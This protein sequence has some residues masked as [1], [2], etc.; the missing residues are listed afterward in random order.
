[1]RFIYTKNFRILFA[2][3][4]IFAMLVIADA[5]GISSGVKGLA[6]KSFGGV[7]RFVATASDQIKNFFSV[8]VTIKSLARENAL[9]N[10][11]INELSFQ[12]ARLNLAKQENT[13]LR[14]ALGLKENFS[15]TLI[16]SEVIQADP[17]GFSQTLVIDKGENQGVTAGAAVVVS[18]GLLVG[19]VTRLLGQ[20]AEVTLITDPAI[21]I[22]AEVVDSGARGLIRGQHGLSLDFDLITQNE[23]IKSQDQV[24]TSGLSGDFPRG[25]LIGEIASVS[26]T[27]SALFQK[28]SVTPAAQLRNLKFLFIAK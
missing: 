5:S 14:R 24:I 23:L 3:F 13:A 18:P 28:A 19:K 6:L 21:T 20:T 25:L 26:T 7:N 27:S 11:R 15:L 10:Q 4:I 9:L 1:M 16:A 8:L 22:N 12:N 2:I 17:T